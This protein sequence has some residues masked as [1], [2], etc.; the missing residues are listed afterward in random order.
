MAAL[1]VT[2]LAEIAIAAL[3]VTTLAEIA[4]MTLGH[5]ETGLRIQSRL[6]ELTTFVPM[7]RVLLL[8]MP[9]FEELARMVQNSV[10]VAQFAQVGMG[11]APVALM[12][13]VVVILSAGESPWPWAAAIL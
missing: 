10:E 2:T 7:L 1:A 6:A 5:A 13:I 8:A 11:I 9:S 3:V 12:E 4:S